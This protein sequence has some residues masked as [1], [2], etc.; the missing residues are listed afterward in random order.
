MKGYMSLV[1]LGKTK[2]NILPTVQFFHN[3]GKILL[4]PFEILPQHLACKLIAC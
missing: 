2:E 3:Y 1:P 4:F